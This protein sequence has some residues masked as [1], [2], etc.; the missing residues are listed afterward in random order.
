MA[1]QVAVALCRNRGI[2]FEKRIC[3]KEQLVEQNVAATHVTE[4]YVMETGRTGVPQN[5][6]GICSPCK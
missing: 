1:A 3:E 4:M 5:N 2:A 6:I